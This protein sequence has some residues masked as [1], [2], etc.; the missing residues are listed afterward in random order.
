MS[1][2][3]MDLME[4]R[5]R[6]NLILLETEKDEDQRVRLIREVE[7]LSTKLTEAENSVFKYDVDKAAAELDS[8][9]SKRLANTEKK[10]MILEASAKVVG[11]VIPA[12]ISLIT[13]SDWGKRFEQ[14]MK[15]EE[16]GRVV[17]T[18]SRVLKFPNVF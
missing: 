11:T 15:F 8:E 12:A 17:S 5:I 18:A 10:K 13:L 3:T 2:E 16:T 9:K 1:N 14:M 4:T 6:E 7:K